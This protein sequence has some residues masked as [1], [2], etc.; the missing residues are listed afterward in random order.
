VDLHAAAGRTS[1]LAAPA[2]P[3]VS[4]VTDT[5]ATVSWTASTGG[6]ADK[7]EVYRQV[8]GASEL[9]GTTTGT[10]LTVANLRPGTG[11]TLNVL[12]RDHDG[13]LSAPSVPIR[14]TTGTPQNSPCAVSYKITNGWG[15]GFVADIVITNRGA[16][17]IN[18]WT[19]NFTFPAGSESV[20]SGWN[21]TWTATGSDVKVT[22]ADFNTTLAGN[23]GTTDIGFVGNNDGAYPSPGAF[24]L[25]GTICTTT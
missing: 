11:Y 6:T 16:D 17:P 10:S 21:G 8:G 19:L 23:G 1:G 14:F 15:T 3:G 20:G 12:A 18:N 22:P 9:L 5:K 24:T 4:A 25:N 7:Y 2:R 13:R